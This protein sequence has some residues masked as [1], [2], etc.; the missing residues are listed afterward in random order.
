MSTIYKTGEYKVNKKQD[1]YHNEYRDEG[2]SVVKYR[3]NRHKEFDGH[4]NNWE[5]SEKKIQSWD[6]NDSSMPDWLRSHI[7]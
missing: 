5:T 1:Y 3:C 2:D 7:K 6:K 4:E